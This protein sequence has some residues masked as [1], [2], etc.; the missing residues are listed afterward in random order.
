MAPGAVFVAVSINATAILN[1]AHGASPRLGEQTC[2]NYVVV[3][4]TK[5][6]Q[7]FS[8]ISETEKTPRASGCRR[9]QRRLRFD[10]CHRGE[11][12]RGI[13]ELQQVLD[14]NFLGAVHVAQAVLHA[15]SAGATSST[16]VLLLGSPLFPARFLRGSQICLRNNV[17]KS[18][19]RARLT[20][21]TRH[22]CRAGGAAYRLSGQ[23]LHALRGSA[24]F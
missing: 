16:S 4:F 5:R 20:R 18:A 22:A 15:I 6:V 8:T 1:E 11:F 3:L 17:S 10:R 7:V 2:H 23:K 9:Q 24:D 21:H 12:D 19:S 14:V 13:E